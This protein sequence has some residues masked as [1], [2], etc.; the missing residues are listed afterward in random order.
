[1]LN[2]DEYAQL[3]RR[4]RFAINPNTQSI[5][6]RLWPFC[7]QETVESTVNSVRPMRLVQTEERKLRSNLP[8][9]I[10]FF[11]GRTSRNLIMTRG[12]NGLFTSQMH[13]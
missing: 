9:F 7:H 4:S 10:P 2:L 13:S 3:I 1:M 11:R 6:T 5:A 12:E 8:E